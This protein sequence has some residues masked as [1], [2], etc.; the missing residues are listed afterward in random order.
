MNLKLGKFQLSFGKKSAPSGKYLNLPY[1]P[2]SYG[3]QLS[4]Q[5]SQQITREGYE[6]CSAIAAV[7]GAW[8]YT[9][10][11]PEKK[12]YNKKSGKE[13]PNHKIKELLR[14][15]NPFESEAEMAARIITYLKTGGNAYIYLA[16]GSGGKGTI[17]ELWCYSDQYIQPVSL[18]GAFVEFYLYRSPSGQMKRI[19]SENIIHIKLPSPKPE[20]P[21]M[22]ISELLLLGREIDCD[23]SLTRFLGAYMKSFGMPGFGVILDETGDDEGIDDDQLKKMRADFMEDFGG[24]SVGGAFIARGVKDYKVL[25]PPLKDMQAKGMRDSLESR[26]CAVTGTPAS[27]A[28]LNVGSNSTYANYET[29][30]RIFTQQRLCPTWK[31][32]ETALTRGLCEVIDPEVEIRHD[33]QGVE[34]LRTAYIAQQKAIAATIYGYQKDYRAGLIFRDDAIQACRLL[35][36]IT[37]EDAELLFREPQPEEIAPAAPAIGDSEVT[38]KG[39]IVKPKEKVV[40]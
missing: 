4:S 9:F 13:L 38:P 33:M 27:I 10:P 11:E 1:S 34:V 25:T 2:T 19:E 23:V 6:A 16:R 7:I 22:A 5:I 12:V 15:P 21:Y 32:V 29:D 3:L 35:M 17:Q 26:F 8:Q 30:L 18:G 20:A 40:T 37:E 14:K 31:N 39:D 24:D 28:G 36:G